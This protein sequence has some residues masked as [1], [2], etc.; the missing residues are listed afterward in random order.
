MKT[1]VIPHD[2]LW[3]E[4]FIKE[5]NALRGVLRKNALEIHHIGST[6]IPDILAKPIIDILIEVTSLD[7]LDQ[8]NSEMES[9]G[10]EVM[11]EFGIET[12]RYFRKSDP[13][14]IR[15]HHLHAFEIGSPHLFRH[16]AFRDYLI[17]HPTQARKYS[18]LKSKL[19][20]QENCTMDSYI[21]GKDS[22]IK[23]TETK[24]LEWVSTSS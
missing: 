12:R 1:F 15:T 13:Q 20:A 23:Q 4:L 18:D 24:A 10:Y 21:A 3:K 9:L 7:L 5:H 2:P 16:L 6:S 19:I 11:G 14:G 8:T 22:F 17:A